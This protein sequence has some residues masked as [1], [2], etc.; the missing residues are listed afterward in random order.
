METLVALR[1]RRDGYAYAPMNLY[2][3]VRFRARPGSKS[4]ITAA[5]REIV[6]P[7]REE[8]GCVSINAF[9]ST[10]DPAAFY[11]HSRWVDQ[12][13]FETHA[14]MPHTVRFINRVELLV[15]HPLEVTRSVLI[16]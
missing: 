14:G 3:F 1:D 7:S 11:I 2:I 9:Q 12:A 6:P 16:L 8:L 10:G 15:D 4:A 13:A 5:L